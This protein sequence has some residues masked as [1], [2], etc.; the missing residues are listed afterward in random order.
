M[1]YH[2]SFW[3]L[4]VT[5]SNDLPQLVK[6]S[7]GKSL[8]LLF[9]SYISFIPNVLQTYTEGVF[10]SGLRHYPSLY[11]SSREVSAYGKP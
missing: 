2:N 1:S 5:R 10:S 3:R 6:A 8:S 9:T 4:T 11:P 7:Y